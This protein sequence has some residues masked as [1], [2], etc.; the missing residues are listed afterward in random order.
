[1]SNTA[2]ETPDPPRRG[3]GR[4]RG[5]RYNWDERFRRREFVMERGIDYFCSQSSMSYMLRNEARKRL[6]YVRLEDID[7]GFRVTV[8]PEP[9]RRHRETTTA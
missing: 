4:P 5:S 3:P 6:L 8:S 2:I 9:F 1:V 7:W